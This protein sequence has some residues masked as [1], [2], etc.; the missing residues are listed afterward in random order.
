MTMNRLLYHA[1]LTPIIE[2]DLV[3]GYL[4]DPP[5]AVDHPSRYVAN[6]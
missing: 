2:A 4:I 1:V 5:S 3:S 6:E